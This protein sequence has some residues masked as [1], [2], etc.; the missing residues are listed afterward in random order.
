MSDTQISASGTKPEAS[1]P[2]GE[3]GSLRRIAFGVIPLVLLTIVLAVIISTDAGMGDRTAPPV[4]VLSVQR[5]AL[6]APGQITVDIVNDGPDPVTIAQ[7]LVDD[8]YWQHEFEGDRTL[9]RLASARI[10]IPYPWVAGETHMLGLVTSTGLVTEAEIPVAVESPHAD[11]NT[12]ARFALIGLYVGIVPVS[13]GLLWF[14]FL[15]GLGRNG[16]RF[17]LALTVGLLLFLVIDMFSEAQE[18]ATTVPATFNGAL[19]VPAI[20]LLT[21]L[22]MSTLA[23]RKKSQDDTNLDVSYRIA[24]GIGLHN[25]AEGLAIGAAFATGA[26]SLGV[27]LVIGF[28]LHNVTE[29]VGIASP[30]LHQRPALHHFVWLATLG[31]IPAV[32]GI[33]IGGFV[34]SP[35]SATIFLAVGIGA[36]AQVIIDV[37][38]MIARG[39][40]RRG[41]QFLGWATLSGVGTGMGVM[42]LTALLVAG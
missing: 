16:M 8:A 7:V 22:V 12:F 36:I 15:R 3:H 41:G 20:A 9:G 39:A 28:T 30:I 25:L 34:Y 32:F 21:L 11:K 23:N 24:L 31:G 10:T 14:P 19:L 38:R 26:V 29:G 33:W 6:P 4:E 13:L 37:S 40:D 35:L 18:V 27:F 42:Y 2:L 1:A 17:I 5:V